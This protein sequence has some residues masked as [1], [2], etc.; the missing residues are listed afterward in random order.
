V[1]SDAL[2][3]C[4]PKVESIPVLLCLAVL[5]CSDPSEPGPEVT[6]DSGVSTTKDAGG[7]QSQ[8]DA[9]SVAP[10]VDGASKPQ[11]AASPSPDAGGT[12]VDAGSAVRPDAGGTTQ[13][14]AGSATQ[15]DAGNTAA[16]SNIQDPSSQVS[17]CLGAGCPAGK[18][19]F[20]ESCDGLYDD[21]LK[22][23]YNFCP[24]SVAGSYCL[25]TCTT[26]NFN[27]DCDLTKAEKYH[28]I[29]C[30]TGKPSISP[31]GPGIGCA[32]TD[33]GATCT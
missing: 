14:D 20:D 33:D 16:A 19:G 31:C 23:S 9:A 21:A 18:C 32:E 13:P 4:M 5:A 2:D 26:G 30:S 22:G 11:D 29:D 3:E 24:T 1:G 12:K 6:P 28:I 27:G 17:L 7:G 8:S 10:V 25:V 15:P